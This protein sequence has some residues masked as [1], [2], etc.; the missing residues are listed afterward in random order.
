MLSKKV[1]E[2]LRLGLIICL[3]LLFFTFPIS[4]FEANTQNSSSSKSI[5]E[6]TQT[7]Y[8]TSFEQEW[9]DS[10][11]SQYISPT[12]WFINGMCSG[13]QK[14]HMNLTHYWSKVEK[15]F[16]Y[17]H[18][19]WPYSPLHP[20][21]ARSGQFS[22]GIWGNDGNQEPEIQKD[23]SDEWLISPEFDFTSYY[24]I[25]LQ[26]WSIYVPNQQITIPF[27]YRIEVDNQYLVKLSDDDGN[28]WKTIADLRESRFR[29]G[30]NQRYD[31][32]NNFDHPIT[33]DLD[34]VK[35]KDNI[36]I[37]W[38]YYY[39]GNG[40]SDL[41]IIDDVSIQGK[42]DSFAPD[43]NIIAPNENNL[44]LFNRYTFPLD[45]NTIII[46]PVDIKVD[47]TDEGTGT[48]LVKFYVDGQ[49]TF[50][51]ETYPFSWQWSK[52]GFGKQTVTAVAY[53]YAGNSNEASFSAIK[54]F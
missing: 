5:Q 15:N 22:A 24:D 44:Y 36:R 53:D 41:W 26:F 4:S 42:Y 34:K 29:Y 25:T 33:L 35:G 14:D 12:E 3:V 47:P 18:T 40:T 43:I 2:E 27:P 1:K 20:P 37:G 38:H 48:K 6:E 39:E 23:Q 9:T 45:G 7:I 51:D 16:S 10:Q 49:L 31:V 30:V 32:Y 11:I 46:G 8:S 54:L 50:T 13:F 19:F 21:F 17:V 28:T 52:T